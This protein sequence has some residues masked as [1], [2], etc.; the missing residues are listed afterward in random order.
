MAKSRRDGAASSALGTHNLQIG[1]KPLLLLLMV[2]IACFEVHELFFDLKA[3][4]GE[5]RNGYATQ[6]QLEQ[7]LLQPREAENA[8]KAKN[9][10]LEDDLPRQN[11]KVSTDCSIFALDCQ[12]RQQYAPYPFDFWNNNTSP[13]ADSKELK[14]ILQAKKGTNT[15]SKELQDQLP[16]PVSQEDEEMCLKYARDTPFNR[17][18]DEMLK[19]LSRV[20]NDTLL[21]YTISDIG[22]AKNMI[23]DVFAMAGDVVG[24]PNSFF[25]V[26]IDEATL[27]LGCRYGYPIMPSPRSGGLEDRVKFTKFQVSLDLLRRGQNFL[28]FEMDVW[29]FRSMLPFLQRQFGDFLVSSH[30][31]NPAAMNIGVYAVIADDATRE[32]FQHCLDV[33]AKIEIHDQTLMQDLKI[34][35]GHQKEGKIAPPKYPNVTFQHF[36]DINILGS[37]VIAASEWPRFTIGTIAIHPLSTVPLTG[38]HGKVQIAKELGVYY[39]SYGYYSSEGRYLWLDRFD[40]SYFMELSSLEHHGQDL[41][42]ENMKWTIATLIAI[43]KR[44]NRI[45]VVPK[46]QADIGRQFLWQILDLKSVEELGVEVRET[47]F[48]NNPKLSEFLSVSRTAVGEGRIFWQTDDKDPKVWK[49]NE[50]DSIDTWFSLLDRIESNALLVNPHVVD[51]DWLY[52]FPKEKSNDNLDLTP[53]E[54]EIYEVYSNLKWCTI[55]CHEKEDNCHE[56]WSLEF[57]NQQSLSGARAVHDCYGKGILIGTMISEE[58]L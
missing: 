46:I 29:F 57:W 58:S 19:K 1:S 47:S 5:F 17:Q 41:N 12:I 33:A 56:N 21:A 34:V 37:D 16:Q 20:V 51:S 8:S 35:S 7:A 18:L 11:W 48:L 53:T 26:A 4:S 32:Y 52:R 23:H 50:N 27:E 15:I 31:K 28:F 25:M 40:N 43:A 24:F 14:K 49:T 45:W 42:Y 39:G 9:T 55:A 2:V 13:E 44:T 22:Y 3:G 54:I 38:P 10:L 36:S 30:Q 6:E